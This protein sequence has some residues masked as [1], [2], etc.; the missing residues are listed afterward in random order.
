MIHHHKTKG[1]LSGQGSEQQA[2]TCKGAAPERTLEARTLAQ[3]SNRKEP[4]R[5]GS[6]NS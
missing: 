5:F 6:D 2:F 1:V 4:V 3:A